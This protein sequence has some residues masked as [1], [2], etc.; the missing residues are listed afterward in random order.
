LRQG[1]H[2]Y[3]KVKYLKV[4]YLKVKAFDGGQNWGLG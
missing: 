3:L 2:Y 4:K 1:E